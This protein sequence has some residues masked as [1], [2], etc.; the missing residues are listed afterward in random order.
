VPP[1]RA[2][3]AAMDATTADAANAVSSFSECFI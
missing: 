2:S 1:A 3:A